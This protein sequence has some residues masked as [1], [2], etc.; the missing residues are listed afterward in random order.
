M[1]DLGVESFLRSIAPG[2]MEC[3]VAALAEN[4][5]VSRGETIEE[6]T[7]VRSGN[8]TYPP[9]LLKYTTKRIAAGE[10]VTIDFHPSVEA[11]LGDLA[12]TVIVEKGTEKQKDALKYAHDLRSL[13][14]ETIRPGLSCCDIH[15]KI[16]E[17]VKKG[18]Y[19][20]SWDVKFGYGRAVAHGIGMGEENWNNIDSGSNR[21][22]KANM[23]FALR[24]NLAPIE[25]QGIHFEDVVVTSETGTR[26]LNRAPLPFVV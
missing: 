7:L 8:R 12:R 15:K 19:F 2:K 26:F 24:V 3:E 6:D 5:V 18:A 1:A 17:C 23:T 16:Y 10:F 20:D 21:V 14:G 13:I 25:S 4:E 22:V 9:G 11:Y